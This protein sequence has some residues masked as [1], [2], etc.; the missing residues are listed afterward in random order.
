MAQEKPSPRRRTKSTASK[1]KVT[2]PRTSAARGRARSGSRAATSLKSFNPRTGEVMREIP[3]TPVGDVAEIVAQARKVQPEWAAIP[4]EGRARMLREVMYRLNERV[5]DIVDI[6]SKETGKPHFEAL[7]F[8]VL[9]A[10]VMIKSYEKLAPKALRSQRVSP[11]SPP[12]LPKLL[13]GTIFC[14]DW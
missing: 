1:S 2:K 3:T 8:D 14:I 4:I 9:P 13:V 6:V 5:D 10:V 7:A 11:L 12:V